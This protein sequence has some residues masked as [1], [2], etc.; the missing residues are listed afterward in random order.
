LINYNQNWIQGCAFKRKRYE[1]LKISRR[2][3]FYWDRYSVQTCD[4]H[5]SFTE[6][7][8]C[9]SIKTRYSK[10][11]A[12]YFTIIRNPVNR[13]ISEFYHVQR[14]ATWSKSVRMC[15]DQDIYTHKCYLKRDWKNVTWKEYT[16]CRHNLGNNR[17]VR[18][19]ADYNE[20]GCKS[21]KCLTGECTSNETYYFERRLL[22]SA[23][24]TIS[25]M[26]FFGIT[27]FQENNQYL[28]EKTFNG[29]FKFLKPLEQIKYN[30]SNYSNN[31]TNIE[32]AVRLNK[33]DIELYEYAVKLFLQRV[34]DYKTNK[35]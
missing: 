22:E 21:L 17:Q 8:K 26:R 6:L 13:Y 24:K 2:Y 15:L 11:K 18:M 1:C 23:K 33:L 28:F 5:A 34:N 16:S 10:G 25:S 14:G 31:E 9:V 4:I 19:L 32:D 35:K 29:I 3:S 27:E 7:V 20:L 30:I 12:H